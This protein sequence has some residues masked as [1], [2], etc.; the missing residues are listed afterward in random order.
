MQTA[1]SVCVRE[2][3]VYVQFQFYHVT[4]LQYSYIRKFAKA[5]DIVLCSI[6]TSISLNRA[7]T[8]D[9]EIEYSNIL[10]S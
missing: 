5:I 4:L 1:L 6:S 7:H 3:N 8:I 10:R 2:C 9:R